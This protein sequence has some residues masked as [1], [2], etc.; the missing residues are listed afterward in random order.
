MDTHS[1]Y[2]LL[3]AYPQQQR[4]GE[5]ASMLLHVQWL[6]CLQHLLHE[7]KTFH[8][9]GAGCHCYH[10]LYMDMANIQVLLPITL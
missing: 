2:V 10:Q 1:D 7:L 6:S 5:R 4:L 3:I 9:S 8:K